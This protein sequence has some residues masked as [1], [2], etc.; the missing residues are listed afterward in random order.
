LPSVKTPKKCESWRATV[1]VER[2]AGNAADHLDIRP[3]PLVIID[4]SAARGKA[5]DSKWNGRKCNPNRD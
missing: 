4:G 5:R 3:S 1:S 2:G